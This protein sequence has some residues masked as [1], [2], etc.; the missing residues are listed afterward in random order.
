MN[1]GAVKNMSEIISS[2]AT[3]SDAILVEKKS[4]Y[5][6]LTFNR[7]RQ[8]NTINQDILHRLSKLLDDV[9]AD[10]DCSMVVISG[11]GGFFCTGMDFSELSAGGPTANAEGND[12]MQLLKKIASLSKVV[13]ARVDG[14]VMAGGVGIVAA[15]DLVFAS[16]NSEFSL[17]EALWG[18]LP[19]CV[20]PFLIRRVG[21]HRAYKMTL[22]T[23]TLNADEA[24]RIGLIDVLSD[25]ID[26][27]IHRQFLRLVRLDSDTVKTM[28]AYFKKMWVFDDAMESVAVDELNRLVNSNRVRAN[29]DNY[30]NHNQFPWE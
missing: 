3:H 20:T 2:E 15:S 7:P 19:A 16:T 28:K 6:I 21:V 17:S 8:R 27:A 12:Y 25:D 23:E 30:V 4:R 13:V 11:C 14:V 1:I 10:S 5:W 18:L 9:E 29:I 26:K 22:T 24:Y